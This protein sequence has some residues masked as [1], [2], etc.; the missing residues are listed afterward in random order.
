MRGVD[1]P[2]GITPRRLS[3]PPR[4]HRHASRWDPSGVLTW[5]PPRWWGTW[6]YPICWTVWCRCS[7]HG[8]TK[9]TSWLPVGRW[10]DVGGDT[11]SI[12]Y[13]ITWNNFTNFCNLISND[14]WKILQNQD[15]KAHHS[16][17]IH[18]PLPLTNK[19][20]VWRLADNIFAYKRADLLICKLLIRLVAVSHSPVNYWY[21]I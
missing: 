14:D 13:L 21:H 6:R 18:Q 10:S 3:Q 16:K 19:W 20:E 15:S 11:L 8:R 9:R 17:A 2:P 1:E 4:H 5:S 12:R 7:S